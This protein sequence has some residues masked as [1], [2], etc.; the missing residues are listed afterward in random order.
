MY[1]Y[2]RKKAQLECSELK[3]EYVAP[4]INTV[5]DPQEFLTDVDKLRSRI[6]NKKAVDI[7]HIKEMNRTGHRLNQFQKTIG[8]QIDGNEK[9]VMLGVI[10]EVVG[11]YVDL[12]R[13]LIEDENIKK[14]TYIL[15]LLK[16]MNWR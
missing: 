11:K 9:V 14:T 5:F 12:R 16:G 8:T 6:F 2:R 4:V 3:E 13:D 1:P 7:E 10:N 15:D